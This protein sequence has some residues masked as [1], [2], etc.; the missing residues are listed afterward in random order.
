MDWLRELMSQYGAIFLAF[1]VTLAFITSTYSGKV[2]NNQTMPQFIGN[3]SYKE[4][5]VSYAKE[6][7]EIYGD[8]IN[9]ADPVLY[10]T[11][12]EIYSG[13]AYNI[14][15]LFWAQDWMGNAIK[16]EVMPKTPNAKVT[17]TDT[18]I[19]FM[20][21]GFYE[22]NLVARD[23]VRRVSTAIITVPVQKPIGGHQ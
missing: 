22:L 9:K 6:R 11:E 4:L 20:D 10:V 14:S 17:I 19:T 7:N 13:K 2:W 3:V 1:F 15:N 5:D 12:N 18:S 8:F 23:R 16:V 21:A